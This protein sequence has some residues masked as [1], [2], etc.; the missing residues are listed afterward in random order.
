M[1]A[2]LSGQQVSPDPFPCCCCC[3]LPMVAI[4]RYYPLGTALSLSAK[5]MKLKKKTE[6]GKKKIEDQLQVAIMS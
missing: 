6:S 3:C 5:L 1:L 2:A 4:S